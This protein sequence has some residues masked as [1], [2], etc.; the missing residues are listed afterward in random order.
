L[1]T[2]ARRVGSVQNRLIG[3][4]RANSPR[5]E[6]KLAS[7]LFSKVVGTLRRAAQPEFSLGSESGTWRAIAMMIAPS[8]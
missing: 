4:M 7:I 2:G 3:H 8:R 1:G 5:T 6:R